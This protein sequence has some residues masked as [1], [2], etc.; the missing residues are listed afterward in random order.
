[1]SKVD[2]E[3]IEAIKQGNI[4]EFEQFFR[5]YY[6]PLLAYANR[7]FDRQAD[8][9]EIVQDLFFKLWEN[10]ARLEITSSLS[11]YLFRSIRNNCLQALKYQ[12]NKTKYQSYIKHQPKD[13]HGNEPLESLE[14]IELNE[15]VN[16]LLSD[17]P[18]RCQEI[19]RLNRFQGLK[20][21]EIA[22]ELSISIKTVEAN[23]SKAL[24]H[25]R[26]NLEEYSVKS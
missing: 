14:F 2:Q 5:E 7:F 11:S 3:R 17:L 6:Q 16:R 1:M 15:K 12:K 9:E 21:R 20:Y 10:R 24:R 4:K 8:A 25:F 18:E 13:S 23:M 19:F 26:T 22:V